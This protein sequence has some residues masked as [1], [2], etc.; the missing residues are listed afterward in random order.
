MHTRF[1]ISTVTL[2]FMAALSLFSQNN[3][4]NSSNGQEENT[5]NH[6]VVKGQTVYGLS[7]MYHVGVED[8]YRLNP[9]SREIIKVGEILKIPQK[10]HTIRTGE[11]LYSVSKTYKITVEQLT[12][13]NPGLTA[14]TFDVGKTI[15]IPPIKI[16]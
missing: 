13:A 12:E 9:S 1:I 16:Q 6:T 8:I 5:V 10:N 14:Q 2:F 7:A 15:R 3:P 11:T 4:V